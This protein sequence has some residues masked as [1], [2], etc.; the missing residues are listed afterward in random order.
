MS[1]L[2]GAEKNNINYFNSI[3]SIIIFIVGLI[4]S[5][6]Y[7]ADTRTYSMH[8]YIT[9]YLLYVCTYK[10]AVWCTTRIIIFLE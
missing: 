9:L 3:N 8:Y 7:L 5:S 4:G 2:K 6:W 1:K 10:C